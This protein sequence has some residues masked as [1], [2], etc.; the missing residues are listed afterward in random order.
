M[1]IVGEGYPEVQVT[2]E[3]YSDIQRDVGGLVDGL[4]EEGFT[5]RL[6]DM[7]GTKGAAVVVC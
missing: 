7:Y 4:P 5:P 3:N 6:I 1:A 2:K